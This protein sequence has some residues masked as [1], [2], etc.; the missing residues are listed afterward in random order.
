MNIE[1]CRCGEPL[2]RLYTPEHPGVFSLRFC[3]CGNALPLGTRCDGS[4]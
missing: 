1:H 4:L 2:E 3:R